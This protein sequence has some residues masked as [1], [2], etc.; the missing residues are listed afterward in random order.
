MVPELLAAFLLHALHVPETVLYCLSAAALL[1][2]PNTG[3]CETDDKE[4]PTGR[5]IS[6]SG[7]SLPWL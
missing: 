7:T 2:A 4:L 3:A 6:S 5:L 1:K